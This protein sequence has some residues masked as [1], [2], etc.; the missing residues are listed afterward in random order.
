MSNLIESLA[1]TGLLAGFAAIWV[2]PA[3]LA[4]RRCLQGG[5]SIVWTTIWCLVITPWGALLLEHLADRKAEPPH[6]S[7]VTT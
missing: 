1:N 5:R 3:V 4:W 6:Q 7:D 2:L